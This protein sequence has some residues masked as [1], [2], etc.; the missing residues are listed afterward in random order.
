V[1]IWF[2]KTVVLE[3]HL[4]ICC[5]T[6]YHRTTPVSFRA[7]D[8]IEVASIERGQ[9]RRHAPRLNLMLFPSSLTHPD[10]LLDVPE[11]CYEVME[12]KS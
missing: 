9:K 2:T 11:D 4:D 12:V 10:R 3:K 8:E 6:G 5:F 1:K 7:G